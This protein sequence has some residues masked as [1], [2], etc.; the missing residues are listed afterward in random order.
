LK[1]SQKIWVSG[2]RSCGAWG[3]GEVYITVR[4]QTLLEK[5]NF[6]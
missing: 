4:Y 5:I 6:V 1:T 2:I 3:I